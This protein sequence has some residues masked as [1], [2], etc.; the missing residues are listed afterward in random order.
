MARSSKKKD[1]KIEY[2]KYDEDS[3]EYRNSVLLELSRHYGEGILPL[4]KKMADKYTGTILFSAPAFMMEDDKVMVQALLLSLTY[5]NRLHCGAYKLITE[6]TDK[7]TGETKSRL[8]LKY[9]YSNKEPETLAE[10]V[11]NLCDDITEKCWHTYRQ[12]VDKD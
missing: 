2:Y 6:V 3:N 1:N 9:T 12:V 5:N 8:H 4:V 11:G 10:F 7:K